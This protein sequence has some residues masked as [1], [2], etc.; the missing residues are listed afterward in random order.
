[1]NVS[2][3]RE[4]QSQFKLTP[5]ACLQERPVA[6]LVLFVADL[7]HPMGGLSAPNPL[8]RSPIPAAIVMQHSPATGI[9]ELP[10][11]QSTKS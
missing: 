7:L 9:E 1:M 5:L 3:R 10:H 6:N 8:I 11:G 2:T 4:N